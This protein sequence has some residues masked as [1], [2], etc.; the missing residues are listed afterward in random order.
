[1]SG[2]IIGITRGDQARGRFCATWTVRSHVSQA[3]NVS[4]ATKVLFGL[5]GDEDENTFKRNDAMSSRVKLDKEKVKELIK[6]FVS[7]NI[8]GTS[9]KTKIS[10]S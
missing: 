2:G 4:Q 7:F 8:S 3:T 6:Q 9:M 5:L 1:M 10:D